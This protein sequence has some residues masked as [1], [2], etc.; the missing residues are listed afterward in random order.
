[1]YTLSRHISK[2]AARGIVQLDDISN[3]TYSGTLAAV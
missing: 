2:T 3:E 1:M